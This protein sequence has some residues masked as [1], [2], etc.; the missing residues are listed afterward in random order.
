MKP[1]KA[2]PSWGR[3]GSS[4]ACWHGTWAGVLLGLDPAEAW[5]A[6]G[7]CLPGVGGEHGRSGVPEL[8]G[9]GCHTVFLASPKAPISHCLA[10]PGSP[11]LQCSWQLPR[12][13]GQPL[14][15][16]L[17]CCDPIEFPN[18]N[19]GSLEPDS[20]SVAPL[21]QAAGPPGPC[22][23]VGSPAAGSAHV[24]VLG[25]AGPGK[26]WRS[27]HP[28]SACPQA[29]TIRACGGGVQGALQRLRLQPLE[30]RLGKEGPL[31]HCGVQ[32]RTQGPGRGRAGRLSW[33]YQIQSWKDGSRKP[34]V[35]FHPHACDG[36]LK[37]TCGMPAGNACG[38]RW[39]LPCH[40]PRQEGLAQGFLCRALCPGL[41]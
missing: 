3:G 7:A 13:W 29:W 41:Y 17:S 24:G 26:G 39:T 32:P 15:L 10:T 27:I 30:S 11:E 22:C 38:A 23:P 18:H 5:E 33:H 9:R 34:G 31:Q 35:E 12:I 1:G 25:T 4:G 21:H 8:G 2:A 6:E 20:A 40:V 14:E 36:S 16:S 37:H 19:L 28:L